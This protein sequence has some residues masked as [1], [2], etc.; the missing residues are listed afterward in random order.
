MSAASGRALATLSVLVGI[1]VAG[2]G[3]QQGAGATEVRDTPAGPSPASPAYDAAYPQLAAFPVRPYLLVGGESYDVTAAENL[4]AGACMA[5]FGFT[6]PPYRK[7]REFLVAEQREA[8]LNTY[9][10]NDLDRARAY[11]YQDAFVRQSG[12]P[13]AGAGADGGPA[14]AQSPAFTLAMVGYAVAHSLNSGV[15]RPRGG[16][17]LPYGCIGEA[18]ETLWG[19][20]MP[21]EDDVARAINVGSFI[22]AEA[23]R[24]V[25]D[26]FA[27]WSSCMKGRGYTFGHPFGPAK[28]PWP[29][30]GSAG[31]PSPAEV[32]TALADV[33]CKRQV[34]LVPRWSAI[35]AEYQ[36][37]AIEKQAL[38]L[39]EARAKIDVALKNA[40]RVLAAGDR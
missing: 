5:R 1:L 10:L 22:K 18:R 34:D 26:L 17:F 23:D 32:S 28:T 19:D 9:G 12:R 31:P 16:D 29:G 11:G 4:L 35:V 15:A 40:N 6:V 21:A 7:D 27:R 36:T 30:R 39:Q 20:P 38:E 13:D 14:R 2:C 33:G 24:R 37:R 25:I 8:D 3:P